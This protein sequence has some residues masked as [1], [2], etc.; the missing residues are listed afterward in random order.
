MRGR[1]GGTVGDGAQLYGRNRDDIWKY[2]SPPCR[3]QTQIRDVL[4]KKRLM[5]IPAVFLFVPLIST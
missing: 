2:I 5:Y 1:F 3:C 4:W